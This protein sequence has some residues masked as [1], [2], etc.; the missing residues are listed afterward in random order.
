MARK[1]NPKLIGGFV[2][3]ALVLV[4]VGLLAFGGGA[5]LTK[6]RT[7]VLYFQGS[8]AG[9]DVGSPVTFRGVKV[10]TVTSVV[11][12]YDVADQHLL[13]PVHIQIEPDKFQ[14]VSGQRNINNIKVLVERGL[15]AQLVVQSLV[16]GQAIVNFDFHPDTPIRL[17]GAEPGALELPTIPSDM[18][19]LKANVSSVLAKI[20]NLPLED[21]AARIEDVL[22]STNDTLKEVQGLV[23]NAGG[24]L[25]NVNSQ[26][27]PISASLVATSDQANATLKTAQARLE[28]RPGEPMQNFNDT[29]GDARRVLNNVD[30]G[31]SPLFADGDRALK[32]AIAALDQAQATLAAAQGAISPNSSLYYELSSTLRELKSAATAIR[33]FAEYIQRNPSALLSGKR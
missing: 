21:I 32:A 14:I 22:N 10:G 26:I 31:L 17:I 7:A 3:G 1:T 4:I 2:L 29:L 19:L 9:L 33:I 24:L 13:I 5:F 8:L 23:K 12:Q 27:S 28:L 15:R 20:T 18:D 6:K 25:T 30:R 11:I 16:T